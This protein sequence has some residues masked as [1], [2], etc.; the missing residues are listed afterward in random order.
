MTTVQSLAGFDS[1][2]LALSL[3]GSNSLDNGKVNVSG[4]NCLTHN[5]NQI[6]VNALKIIL[7][8]LT[9]F[10]CHLR[11]DFVSTSDLIAVDN[12]APRWFA[13]IAP[14]NNSMRLRVSHP[15]I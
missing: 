11:L 8:P 2:H 6:W 3:N 14:K 12:A 5:Q 9:K 15:T 4:L 13:G 1:D 7:G 10:E